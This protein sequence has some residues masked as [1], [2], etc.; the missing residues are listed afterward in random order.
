ME[1]A[2]QPLIVDIETEGLGGGVEIGAVNEQCDFFPLVFHEC[3]RVKSLEPRCR[4]PDEV[5][6]PENQSRIALSGMLDRVPLNCGCTL[7]VTTNPKV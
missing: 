2:Q 7:A 6:P 3:S 4:L 1:L 5:R